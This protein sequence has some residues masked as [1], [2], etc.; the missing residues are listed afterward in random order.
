[1]QTDD[2][3]AASDI[4]TFVTPKTNQHVGFVVVGAADVHFSGIT[5]STP[6]LLCPASAKRPSSPICPPVRASI[7]LVFL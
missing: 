5:T 1:M 6:I 2:L 7:L 3:L 4:Q